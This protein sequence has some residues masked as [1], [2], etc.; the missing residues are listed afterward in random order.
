MDEIDL[1]LIKKLFENSRLTYRELA[2]MTD[3]GVSA[4]HKRIRKLE[5]EKVINAYT[6]RPSIYALKSLWIIIFGTS[7][8]KSLEAISIELGQHENVEFV[9]I[10]GAKFLYISG[11]LRNISELQ[12]YSSHVSKI[13]QIDNP[14][15]GIVNVPYIT[16]PESLTTIDYKILKT[17][18]R[19]ARKSITD[20]ADDI[21]LSAKTVRK[22]LN[23]MIENNLA[24]FSI[25]Y[26]P[27]YESSFI[28]VFHVHLKEG[29]DMNSMFQYIKEKYAQN[30]THCFNYS[31]IPNFMTITAWTKTAR[32]SRI[33]QKELQ[34]EGFKD[35]T[36]HIFL[37]IKWYQCWV[38]HILKTQ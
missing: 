12:D 37:S 20:I 35:I 17:L 32:D 29:T 19:D 11:F 38:D 15:V 3:L 36:P 2:A 22:R 33:L 25:E 23:R 18:N 6:A 13:A 4:I 34:S 7:N 31:N 14:T 5:E 21:G 9:G 24:L 27:F 1:F 8:A 30:I 28:A 26:Y 16:L 10:S